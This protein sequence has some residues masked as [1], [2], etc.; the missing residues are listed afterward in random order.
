MMTKY[1]L[2]KEFIEVLGI[3]AEIHVDL[4]QAESYHYPS[5]TAEKI[6]EL[7]ELIGSKG[8]IKKAKSL[9]SG[10]PFEYGYLQG[11]T[12]YVYGKTRPEA[13]QKLIIELVKAEVLDKEEVKG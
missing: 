11:H 13:L 10:Y 12:K 2:T 1:E 7:E 4:Y 5:L 3:E 9:I 8:Y 6:L